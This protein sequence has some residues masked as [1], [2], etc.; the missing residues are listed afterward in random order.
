[1]RTPKLYFLDVGLAAC[2]QGWRAIEPLLSSPQVGPLFETLVLD[3]LVRARDHRGLPI[4]LHFWRTK[5]GEEVD[6]LVEAHGL[7]GPQ[8]I[9]IEAKFA[10]QHVDP[11]GIPA[12]LARQLPDIREI[13]V[14]TPGGAEARLSPTSVQIPIRHLADRLSD[15]VGSALPHV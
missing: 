6:F 3:E 4:G 5:E 14:V 11:V 15:A 1:M 2:L 8:W 9:A 7:G 10:I 13:W 12:A